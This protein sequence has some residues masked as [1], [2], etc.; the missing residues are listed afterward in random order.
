MAPHDM[1]NHQMMPCFR[2]SIHHI[3]KLG[4]IPGRRRYLHYVIRSVHK[5]LSQ[6]IVPLMVGAPPGL[7][8]GCPGCIDDGYQIIFRMMIILVHPGE[9]P[10]YGL[11]RLGKAGIGFREEEK[12]ILRLNRR[13]PRCGFLRILRIKGLHMIPVGAF[14]DDEEY[15]TIRFFFRFLLKAVLQVCLLYTSVP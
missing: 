2:N 8:P 6:V 7:I 11:R 1:K 12:S 13:L 15:I 3:Q 4:I 14:P 5:V 9:H 10:A